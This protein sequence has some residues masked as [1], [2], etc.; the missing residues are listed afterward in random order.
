[1]IEKLTEIGEKLTVLGF[2][3]AG[4]LGLF[5]LIRWLFSGVIKLFTDWF[6]EKIDLVWGLIEDQFAVLAVD[7]AP[8]SQFAA[9]I[10]KANAVVP[11]DEAWRYMLLYLSF[12]SV[13]VGVKWTRNL[14]PGL[15]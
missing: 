1:M 4:A 10:S 12:Y 14:I 11:L 9:M 15:K 7:M 8:G 2:Q 6:N 5:E 3:A 13:V